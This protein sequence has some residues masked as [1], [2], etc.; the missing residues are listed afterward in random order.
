MFNAAS[1]PSPDKR[2]K[3]AR[4][5]FEDFVEACD[6]ARSPEQVKALLVLTAQQHGFERIL[7]ASHGAREHL[8]AFC[9]RAHNLGETAHAMLFEADKP[10]PLFSAIEAAS[11][12]IVWAEA[13]AWK[14]LGADERASIAALFQTCGGQGVWISKKIRS[15]FSPASCSLQTGEDLAPGAARAVMRAAFYALY[16]IADLQRPPM[17]RADKLTT[18]EQQCMQLAVLHGLRP[19]EVAQALGVSINTVRT[20]RKS[21]C[22]RLGARSQEEAVWRMVT[23]GQLFGRGRSGRQRIWVVEDNESRD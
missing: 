3:V 8:G 22:A 10:H 21:A 13:S 23:T 18:R 16:A 19:R 11:G 5:R 15:T 17:L 2:A 1:M 20:L 7:L 4:Y 14:G 9:V 12:H 6:C